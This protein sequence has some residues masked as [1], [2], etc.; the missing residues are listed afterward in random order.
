MLTSMLTKYL[1]NFRNLANIYSMHDFHVTEVKRQI[2][3][4]EMTP[5]VYILCQREVI[6]ASI[7]GPKLP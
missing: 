4:V 1:E 5:D 7:S 6:N 3:Y 2:K